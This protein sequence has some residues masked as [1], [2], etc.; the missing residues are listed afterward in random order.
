[1]ADAAYLVQEAGRSAVRTGS[2]VVTQEILISVAAEMGVPPEKR[3]IGF[4]IGSRD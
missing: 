3:P 1:M 2:H 4:H